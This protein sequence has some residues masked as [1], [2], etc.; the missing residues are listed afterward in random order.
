V[1]NSHV[2][3]NIFPATMYDMS[4]A[5]TFMDV[6]YS[7]I[8]HNFSCEI[9]S[10][11]RV[12][13]VTAREEESTVLTRLMAGLFKPEKGSIAVFGTSTGEATAEKLMD[14]RRKLGIVTFHGGLVSNLKMWEN[15]FLPFYYHTGKPKPLDDKLAVNYLD[16]LNCSEK[17]KLFPAHLSLFEKRVAAFTRAAIMKPDIMI[18]CN[19][20]DRISNPEQVLFASV[21]DAFHTEKTDRT[22]I[23]LAS[24]TDLP[25]QSDFDKVLYIH[26]EQNSGTAPK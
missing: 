6:C 3:N 26:P 16:K 5:V 9:E 18:Y 24:T 22:S 2:D 23:Y 17:H 11:A 7:D 13:V 4:V 1:S 15:I 20:F 12:L 25:F 10:G 14:S 19:T 21:L 8:L